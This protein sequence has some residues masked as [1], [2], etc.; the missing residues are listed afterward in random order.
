MI[1]SDAAIKCSITLSSAEMFMTLETIHYLP[2]NDGYKQ[3]GILAC[4]PHLL[5]QRGGGGKKG[6]QSWWIDFP[7]PEYKCCPLSWIYFLSQFIIPHLFLMYE[8]ELIQNKRV[9]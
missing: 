6:S 8:L 7:S 5:C 9:S 1:E 3:Q 2:F 4:D